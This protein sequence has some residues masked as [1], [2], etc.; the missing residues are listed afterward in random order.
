MTGMNSIAPRTSRIVAVTG[1]G[2]G[3]G[4]V[5]AR[6]FADE[7]T[8]VIAIGQHLEPL[9]ETAAA[10]C[11]GAGR[12]GGGHRGCHCPQ[13]SR[14]TTANLASSSYG[15]SR[16]RGH[17]R[18]A[19]HAHRAAS[20]RPPCPRCVP[21]LGQPWSAHANALKCGSPS[22]TSTPSAA[23]PRAAG[24]P[25]RPCLAR[26]RHVPVRP[27]RSADGPHQNPA[28]WPLPDPFGSAAVRGASRL[29]SMASDDPD[30]V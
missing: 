24:T 6:A 9:E 12:P 27:R 26:E 23:S 3:I 14:L 1:A 17:R 21:R 11:G 18:R 19:G 2:T 5:T 30:P 7:G 29:C 28:T 13:P 10:P 4:R 15:P 22:A 16:W 8:H 20:R 25:A